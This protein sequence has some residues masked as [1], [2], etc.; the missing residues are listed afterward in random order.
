MAQKSKTVKCEAHTTWPSKVI[1][2][3]LLRKTAGE[4]EFN[5]ELVLTSNKYD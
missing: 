5:A 2:V 3:T 1:L 4:R